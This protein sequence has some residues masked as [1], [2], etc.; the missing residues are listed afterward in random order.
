M[1]ALPVI[2]RIALDMR[3]AVRLLRKSQGFAAI[4]IVTLAVGIGSATATFSILD[5]WLIRALPRK[6]ADQL[7][8][9]FDMFDLPE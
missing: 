1:L 9:G 5:P 4:A 7:F 3:Y 6:D 8:T 2:E